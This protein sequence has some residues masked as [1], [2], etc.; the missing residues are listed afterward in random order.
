MVLDD[1]VVLY[2][3]SHLADAD[4]LV[5]AA[6]EHDT[7]GVDDFEGEQQ[8]KNF[9]LMGAAVDEIAVEHVAAAA[10]SFDAHNWC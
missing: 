9:E 8:Q 3:Q 2:A 5:I 1:C 7:G 6:Q 10:A 4:T